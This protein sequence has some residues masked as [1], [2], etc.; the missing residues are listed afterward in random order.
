MKGG[1]LQLA[2]VGREDSVLISNPEIFHFKKT[3]IPYSKFT[4]DNNSY[5]LGRK[6]F[7]TSFDFE[8]GKD[9]DLLK[10]LMFYVDIPYFEILKKIDNKTVIFERTESDKIYYNH[11]S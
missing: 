6:T 10:D 11:N 5:N 8:I 7:D 3:Y 2:T 4:I 9:G 1:L